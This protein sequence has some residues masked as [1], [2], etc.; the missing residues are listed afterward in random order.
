MSEQAEMTEEFEQSND[1][2][3]PEPDG[4]EPP[5]IDADDMADAA[6]EIESEFVGDD[7]DFEIGTDSDDDMMD[8][9]AGSG[10]TFGDIYCNLL[11]VT[12]NMAAQNVGSGEPIFEENDDGS[13]DTTLAKQLE[14]D[15]YANQVKQKYSAGDSMS[16]EAALTFNTL[17]FAGAVMTMDSEI[18]SGLSERMKERRKNKDNEQ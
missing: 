17:M 3:T 6:S 7:S 8:M 13:I 2:Q 11:A 12:S 4:E 5:D 9:M 1:E 15:K 10:V 14:I 18:M 16:P